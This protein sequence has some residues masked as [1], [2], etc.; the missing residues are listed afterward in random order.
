MKTTRKQPVAVTGDFN[1]GAASERLR[2]AAILESPEG[3]RNPGMALK[4]ALYTQN[5]AE[6]ARIILAE[7]PAANPYLA[8]MEQ[9]GPIGLSATMT[10]INADPKA[11]RME[12]IKKNM[13]A[14]NAER[15]RGQRD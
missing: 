11:A 1:A 10:E 2:I 15:R 9:H 12:E 4:L 3:K 14:F 8:A 13:A 6:T 5:D 7:A